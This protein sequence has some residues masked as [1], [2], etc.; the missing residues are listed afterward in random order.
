M[1]PGLLLLAL[2][3]GGTARAQTSAAD[4]QALAKELNQLLRDP[5]KPQ[6]E[7]E[8]KLSGC[9]AEQIIRD[10]KADV[11]TKEPINVSYN[12]G[13]SGWAVNLANGLFELKMDF[14]WSEVT[15]IS[16][17]HS[18]D[19]EDAKFYDLSIKRQRKGST[20]TFDLTLYTTDEAVVKSLVRR[21]ELVRK[22]CGAQN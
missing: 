13:N 3:L 11:K 16:Y 20:T 8:L 10:R 5:G 2:L 15:A 1:K 9:H 4:K 6:Q 12:K 21:L 18:D 7:V 22:S 17:A 14:E 19:K